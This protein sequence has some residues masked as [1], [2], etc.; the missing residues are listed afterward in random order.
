MMFV[1]LLVLSGCG[2]G[3]TTEPAR[4]P[5]PTVEPAASG[6]GGGEAVATGVTGAIVGVVRAGELEP[7]GKEIDMSADA[8]C[9]E[10]HPDEPVV[11]ESVIVSADGMLQNVL[12]YVSK[13]LAKQKYPVP[14]EPFLLDQKGCRYQP[15]V[16]GM[17]AGQPIEIRN[18]D[19]TFHNVQANP[20]LNR[21]FN[22][23]IARQNASFQE[24]F[25]IPEVPVVFRCQAHPWMSAYGGVF[26]HP[27]FAVTDDQG[28]FRLDNLPAGE[29]VI[30]AWHEKGGVK[31]VDVTI[32][33]EGD[34][35]VELSY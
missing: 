26:E 17:R 29:Y 10:A 28:R 16:F 22:K 3:G 20:K 7:S 23:G 12:V 6:T 33:E 8:K 21:S 9:A 32:A 35:E 14:A 31:T 4:P 27:F 34:V 30:E 15:H 5:E 13:G 1:A 11:D 18:S 19:P 2:G 25:P 24:T